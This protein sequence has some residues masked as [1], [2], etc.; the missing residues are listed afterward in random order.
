M[1]RRAKPGATSLCARKFACRRLLLAYPLY[2]W[3]L[4]FL[5]C[6]FCIVFL[7]PLVQVLL[8]QALHL[9]LE[10][11]D[12]A[13]LSGFHTCSKVRLSSCLARPATARCLV[14]LGCLKAPSDIT[15]VKA[16]LGKDW[17]NCRV[18]INLQAASVYCLPSLNST[19][20]ALPLR[21][22]QG[23]SVWKC[24]LGAVVVPARVCRMLLPAMTNLKRVPPLFGAR[25]VYP[26]FGPRWFAFGW[27][28]HRRPFA[29]AGSHC[30]HRECF[31]WR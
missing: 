4:L 13:G 31:S 1:D 18:S 27:S 28:G 12:L 16:Y 5:S 11:P 20:F 29:V 3:L 9:L 7:P 21:D 24:M 2:F 25:A 14:G 26:V 23:C 6:L 22:Q 15:P 10:Q 8:S 17:T 30:R 19:S